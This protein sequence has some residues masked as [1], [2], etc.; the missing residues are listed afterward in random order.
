MDKKHGK[1]HK[2]FIN[3]IK[4][5]ICLG[6]LGHSERVPNCNWKIEYSVHSKLYKG[7]WRGGVT[8]KWF[9]EGWKWGQCVKKQMCISGITI[10]HKN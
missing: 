10:E 5:D 6:F 9:I 7:K 3:Y 8:G 2:T 1:F 4:S